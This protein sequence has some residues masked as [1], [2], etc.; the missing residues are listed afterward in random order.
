MYSVDH[1]TN[2]P[3]SQWVNGSGLKSSYRCPKETKNSYSPIPKNN[4]FSSSC[5]SNNAEHKMNFKSFFFWTENGTHGTL[6]KPKIFQ[7]H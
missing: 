5:S 4:S 1:G 7:P 3:V 2:L 6:M